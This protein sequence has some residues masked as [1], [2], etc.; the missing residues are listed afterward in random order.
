MITKNNLKKAK[1]YLIILSIFSIFNLNYLCIATTTAQLNLENLSNTELFLK[2]NYAT[3]N[4]IRSWLSTIGTLAFSYTIYK[5]YNP[6]NTSE[7]QNHSIV[8]TDINFSKVA[9]QDEAIAELRDILHSIKNPE[10]YKKLGARLINGIL[11]TGPPGNG[12]TLLAR[13]LAG[14]LKVPIFSKSGSSFA[15][16]YAGSG[17]MN[18]RAIYTDAKIEAIKQQSPVILFI[19]EI[20]SIGT[21]RDSSNHNDKFYSDTL[22]Q[23]L[24]EMDGISKNEF[25]V[26]TIGATNRKNVLDKALLRPGRFDRVVNVPYPDLHG[27][28]EILK[29]YL[30]K[31]KTGPNISLK[32]LARG[33]IGFSGAKIENLINEAAIIASNRNANSI[34]MLDFENA[35]DKITI[36]QERKSKTR[37]QKNLEITAYHEAGHALVN[38][39]LPE[40]TDPLHKVTILARGSALGVTFRLP[41]EDKE[42]KSKAEYLN[43]IAIACAGKIAEELK[44]NSSDT[45]A[46]SDFKTA[47]QMAR[48]MVCS[49]GMSDKLGHIVYDNN[50]KYSEK[51]LALIDEEVNN[52]VN[53]C[54]TR[55]TKLI[56]EN[57]DKLEKLAQELLKKETLYAHEVYKLLD[58]EPREDLRL[59]KV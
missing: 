22:N 9:G 11:L 54:Y 41:T 34:S 56:S 50:I 59:A 2:K 15:A 45:G 35:R 36:G 27:R 20:D 51:T 14:E 32:K 4:E 13:A 18:V 24:V 44:F 1:F 53:T 55:A 48:S 31:V 5:Q 26:I 52:I 7:P 12:K 57:L 40:N 33:T 49:Y 10:K 25:P 38:V 3:L 47:S 30:K 58:I 16:L 21:F 23:L 39:L 37:L 8:E 19:D 42:T 6:D 29:T 17:A 43:S 28:S 46:Y